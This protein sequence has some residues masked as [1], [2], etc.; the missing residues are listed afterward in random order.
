LYLYIAAAAEAVS[1]VLVAERTAQEGQEPEGS[2]P[3]TGAQTIQRPVYYVSEVLHEAKAKY[4]ETHKLLYAP[5]F[6]QIGP[7]RVFFPHL[8]P[9]QFHFKKWTL[10]SAPSSL[11]PSMCVPAPILL[12]LI[13][14]PPV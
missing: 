1:M 3:A 2:E 5:T 7:F 9:W 8:C 12:A 10:C 6:L 4:L 14:Q 11:A 13:R